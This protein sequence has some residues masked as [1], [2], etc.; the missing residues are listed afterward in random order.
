[1]SDHLT[2]L[3]EVIAKLTKLK[4]ILTKNSANIADKLFILKKLIAWAPNGDDLGK[5]CLIWLLDQTENF[6]FEVSATFTGED[7]DIHNL[8]KA[9][10]NTAHSMQSSNAQTKLFE[11]NRALKL[12]CH[13]SFTVYNA[14]QNVWISVCD[15][16]Y[17]RNEDKPLKEIV[18]N[19][20]LYLE[21]CEIEL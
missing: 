5:K 10:G 13:F 1:M 18:I 17:T 8:G 14:P 4:D 9:A 15:I 6:A 2:E 3:D 11:I 16:P 21:I 19:D 12:K 7:Q 20:K